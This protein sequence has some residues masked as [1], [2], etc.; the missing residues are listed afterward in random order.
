MVSCPRRLSFIFIYVCYVTRIVNCEICSARQEL[1]K[2]S[3]ETIS[4]KSY[5]RALIWLL[6]LFKIYGELHILYK[7]GKSNG[8]WLTFILWL[9]RYCSVW[10]LELPVRHQCCLQQ[11][12]EFFVTVS[13]CT[14]PVNFKREQHARL[15]MP[16][17]R[18]VTRGNV[19]CYSFPEF[20][21]IFY[22]R[23]NFA[24]N[25]LRMSELR[26]LASLFLT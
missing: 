18:A 22:V 20:S 24:V 15:F 1:G 4:V 14:P 16:V 25:T 10:S 5:P 23:C 7:P 3:T 17:L 11:P 2:G 12:L 6:S 26:W 13:S 19:A 9:R 8:H 21:N